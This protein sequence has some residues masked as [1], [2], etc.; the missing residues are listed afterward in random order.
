[1]CACVCVEVEGVDGRP[2]GG[3]HLCHEGEVIHTAAPAECGHKPAL[4]LV[5]KLA[6]CGAQDALPVQLHIARN[7]AFKD[8]TKGEEEREKSLCDTMNG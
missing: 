2:E 5:D 3:R 4:D 1:M 6:W 7:L 8:E